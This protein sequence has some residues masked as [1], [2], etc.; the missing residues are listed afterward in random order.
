MN[1]GLDIEAA[2]WLTVNTLVVSLRSSLFRLHHDISS[3]ELNN[4]ILELLRIF[5]LVIGDRSVGLLQRKEEKSLF[6]R[7][8]REWYSDGSYPYGYLLNRSGLS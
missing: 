1:E 8:P 2:Y 6:H 7:I 4:Y 3:V 5:C